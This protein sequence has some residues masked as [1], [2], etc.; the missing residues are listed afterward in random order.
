M[1]AVI[2]GVPRLAQ[3]N[4]YHGWVCPMDCRAQV[5]VRLGLVGL[6][7][8]DAVE[9]KHAQVEED[10]DPDLNPRPVKR[11]IGGGERAGRVCECCSV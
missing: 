5:V 1:E 8:I 7:D 9:E 4:E 2:C 6:G 3:L 11:G 10:W